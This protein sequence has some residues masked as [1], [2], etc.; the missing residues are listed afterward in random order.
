MARPSQPATVRRK[1][2]AVAEVVIFSPIMLAFAAVGLWWV[3]LIG[4]VLFRALLWLGRQMP[5]HSRRRRR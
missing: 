3:G 1:M 5:A 4:L 2:P